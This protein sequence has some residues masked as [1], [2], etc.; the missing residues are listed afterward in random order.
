MDGPAVH[1]EQG[2]EPA[3]GAAVH[4][5]VGLV[6]GRGHRERHR[7]AGPP[8]ER[9]VVQEPGEFGECVADAAQAGEGAGADGGRVA[10][11]GAEGVEQSGDGREGAAGDLGVAVGPGERGELGEEQRGAGVPAGEVRAERPDPPVAVGEQFQPEPVG[12]GTALV[13]G[14]DELV[15]EPPGGGQQPFGLGRGGPDVLRHRTPG[16][17]RGGVGGAGH[18]GAHDPLLVLA[19]DRAERGEL[20]LDPGQPRFGQLPG[21][22][23]A[24]GG[25][26]VAGAGPGGE[27]RHVAGPQV[28]DLVLGQPGTAGVVDRVG[29]QQVEHG[30]PGARLAQHVGVGGLVQQP[31]VDP[32]GPGDH[33]DLGVREGA[34]QSARAGEVVA[35]GG[36]RRVPGAEAG[37]QRLGVLGGLDLG[38]AEP[39]PVVRGAERARAPHQPHL[40]GTGAGPVHA[41]DR[42]EPPS[43]A[44]A[45][46]AGDVR[47]AVVADQQLGQ[48]ADAVHGLGERAGRR[49]LLGHAGAGSGTGTGIGGRSGL[50]RRRVEQRL[51]VHQ[52]RVVPAGDQVL[53]VG[54]GAVQ[55][56]QQREQRA[57]PPVEPLD[58]VAGQAGAGLGELGPAVAAPVEQAERA[59]PGHSRL[60]AVPAEQG[61]EVPVRG[62]RPGAVDDGG[63][64]GE[65]QHGD[66]PPAPVAVAGVGGDGQQGARVAAAQQPGDQQCPVGG[67]AVQQFGVGVG[68][69]QAGAGEQSGQ[70]GVVA[71]QRGQALAAGGEREEG[72]EPL[73]RGASGQ[74]P[75]R[76]GRAE[77]QDEGAGGDPG[78]P[79]GEPRRELGAQR[80]EV[81]PALLVGRPHGGGERGQQP[82]LRPV[83]EGLEDEREAAQAR[84]GGARHHRADGRGGHRGL[85][86]R[87][88]VRTGG[89]RGPTR[90]QSPFPPRRAAGTGG[91]ETS[92]VGTGSLG[93]VGLVRVGTV[94]AVLVRV[95][96]VRVGRRRLRRRGGCGGNG[97]WCGW[98]RWCGE[99]A[100]HRSVRERYGRGN[101]R[102]DRALNRSG[103]PVG[104]R[105][106][107]GVHLSHHRTSDAGREPRCRRR[108]C[109]RC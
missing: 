62:G 57:L 18:R 95:G 58:V 35:A 42:G 25:P 4:A 104:A 80:G 85:G 24:A 61:V 87:G 31:G 27:Q 22:P 73:L 5:R 103:A 15:A 76:P 13:G 23:P 47:G 45:A 59:Q 63:A 34:Q 38:A 83:G 88:P 55:D 109:P 60:R 78:Q 48:Q 8:G 50:A 70:D 98:C 64:V 19:V 108:R 65:V 56:V 1:R 54:V 105:A 9:R 12:A 69:V 29:A 6:L 67:E 44:T 106:A 30:L 81:D 102:C 20:G 97:G 43:G 77:L 39:R 14:G 99:V 71:Q 37:H 90:G 75:G 86:E 36:E 74:P 3:G 28:G 89:G 66:G 53:E 93:G 11:V 17:V 68:G 40:V 82:D 91:P 26:Q 49:V 32:G 51:D 101:R 52:D 21:Q 79:F 16:P 33:P 72:A 2:R 94:R 100:G 10:G 107:H 41:V 84:V 46:D 96:R 92:V 7:R